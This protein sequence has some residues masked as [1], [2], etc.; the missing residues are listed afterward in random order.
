VIREIGHG[1]G[2]LTSGRN[3]G[4]L[5]AVSDE[6]DGREHGRGSSV[7]AGGEGRARERVKLCE[8]R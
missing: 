5:G 6:L 8:M 1:D 3:L 7:V 2:C 4:R